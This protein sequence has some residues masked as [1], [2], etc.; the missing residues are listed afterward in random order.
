[1]I[2]ESLTEVDGQFTFGPTKTHQVRELPLP[3]SLL[4]DLERHLDTEVDM[5]TDA[6]LFTT[7]T[8]GPV[9][10]LSL[11]CSFEDARRFGHARSSITT[12]HYAR[13][14]V[15]GDAAVADR[16]DQARCAVRAGLPKTEPVDD[17]A[18]IWHGGL[19]GIDEGREPRE[20]Y[21]V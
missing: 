19:Q 21:P 3:R 6:L 9:R 4:V 18:R 17:L 11:R 14:M 15:G 12:R 5:R 2:A 8:G 1:V 10:Y 13:P 7:Q 16:L 20:A